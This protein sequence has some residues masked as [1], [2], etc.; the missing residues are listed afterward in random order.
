MRILLPARFYSSLHDNTRPCKIILLPVWEYSSLHE[1]TPRCKI[2]LLP[3]WEYSSLHEYTPPCI[4]ILFHTWVYSSL[5]EFTPTYIS[6]LFPTYYYYYYYNQQHRSKWKNC[7]YINCFYNPTS[8]CAKE[9]WRKHNS[10]KQILVDC[11]LAFNHPQFRCQTQC[12]EGHS[13]SEPRPAGNTLQILT[14]Y[15][16]ILWTPMDGLRP[17][18]GSV[19]LW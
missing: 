1:N 8:T 9:K 7:F 16:L 17:Q 15:S 19:E 14:F 3:A 18:L 11:N 10:G 13:T 2:I 5:H 12:T 4:R 6:I